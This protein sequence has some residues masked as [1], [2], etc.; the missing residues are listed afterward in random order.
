VSATTP[1]R[2]VALRAKKPRRGMI[3]RLFRAIWVAVLFAIVVPSIF[4]GLRC[5]SGAPPT[6][7]APTGPVGIPGYVRPEA[8]TFL[9]LPEWFIVYSTDEQ[10]RLLQRA[11]PWDFPYF[12]SISQYWR[13]YSDA[14]AVTKT[15]YPFETGYH[16]MLGVIGVSFTV[17]NALKGVYENT[18]GRLSGWFG[19]DTPEDAFAAKTAAEYGAFMHTVPWY[20]F[21]FGARLR[22]LWAGSP[23]FGPR[24]VRKL[25]RRAALTAEYGIKAAYAWVIELATRSA[26]GAEDLVVHS[27]VTGAADDVLRGAKAELVRRS[28][29][30]VAIVKLPRYEAFTRSALALL[31]AGVR[32]VDVA[33]NEEMLVTAIAPAALDE[34]ALGLA[35]MATRPILTEP[36]RKRVAFRVP[37][38]RLHEIV[39]ALRA[40]GAT[41]EH[42][43]DY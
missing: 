10:A 33:G 5:Y 17:E 9:T 35:V 23:L 11:P 2:L 39:P 20:E 43:Y 24:P 13:Y 40:R 34:H 7:R 15:A 38:E 1:K 42:L 29:D 27:R 8:F 4:I 30:G 36:Q 21:P 22:Q 32:F 37:V 12:G 18:V 6:S 26:Y 3:R 28:R 31:D 25:E 14:C 16:V 19:R 41:I